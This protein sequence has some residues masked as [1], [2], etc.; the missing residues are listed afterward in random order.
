MSMFSTFIFVAYAGVAYDDGFI[1]V[2]VMWS[3][4]PA[5]LIAG[6]AFAG[7]WR[8]AKITTPVEYLERRFDSSTR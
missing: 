7:R 5:C 8:R 6:K 4:V 3:T 2:V 1:A